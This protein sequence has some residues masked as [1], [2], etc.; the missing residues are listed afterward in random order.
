MSDLLLPLSFIDDV[1]Q[2]GYPYSAIKLAQQATNSRDSKDLLEWILT[3]ENEIYVNESNKTHPANQTVQRII[4]L[5]FS[6]NSAEL[7]QRKT[8]SNDVQ[9][10]IEWILDHDPPENYRSILVPSITNRLEVTTT[11]DTLLNDLL[12]L[13]FDMN[14]MENCFTELAINKRKKSNS[15]AKRI[16]CID[17]LINNS[18]RKAQLKAKEID[19]SRRRLRIPAPIKLNNYQASSSCTATPPII[20]NNF[21]KQVHLSGRHQTIANDEQEPPLTPEEAIMVSIHENLKRQSWTIHN[22]DQLHL[23]QKYMKIV[24]RIIDEDRHN[25]KRYNDD[26]ETQSIRPTTAKPSTKKIFTLADLNEKDRTDYRP[27]L[28]TPPRK[29]HVPGFLFQSNLNLN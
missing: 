24:A 12:K 19:R 4:E 9:T 5:G 1:L 16:E 23:I 2:M 25:I 11:N 6:K 14:D 7:A 27:H 20:T 13:G 21:L 15:A 28:A 10:L 26:E 3:H 17:W 18:Q 29:F 8:K 22:L